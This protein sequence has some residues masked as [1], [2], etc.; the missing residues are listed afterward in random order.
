MSIQAFATTEVIVNPLQVK[1]FQLSNQIQNSPKTSNVSFAEILSSTQKNE[2]SMSVIAGSTSNEQQVSVISGSSSSVEN[3]SE[4]TMTDN[5]GPKSSSD[6]TSTSAMTDNNGSKENKIE[7][8]SSL[9]DK[10]G[11]NNEVSEQKVREN[12]NKNVISKDDSSKKDT[13]KSQKKE[14]DRLSELLQN[15]EK[16]ENIDE[17]SLQVAEMIQNNSELTKKE[18]SKNVREEENS[19]NESNFV[20]NQVQITNQLTE[21]SQAQ[22]ESSQFNFSKNEEDKNQLTLDKEGK[23]TV[24]DLRTEIS[25]EIKIEEKS[26]LKVTE[27]KQTSENSAQITI[28]LAQNV[29][30]DVL[31][32]NSQTASSDGSTF[33]AMLNN[34]IQ[35]NAS[36]FVKAGNIVLKDNNQGTIDLVLHPD[37]LGNVKIH[38]SLDGKTLTGQITVNT[39]EALQVFKDNAE[40]LREAFIKNGFDGASFDV[41]FGNGSN[42]NSDFEF[43]QQNDGTS[44]LAKRI[45]NNSGD[46]AVSSDIEGFLNDDNYSNYSVNIVA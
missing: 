26:D 23:I 29:N 30:S 12:D 19:E 11:Q 38:L 15:Q 33:Q 45:Y 3:S 28:D 14:F 10:N 4:S 8:K 1:D 31:A 7:Q 39:K 42:S 21:N 20:N 27:V 13:K 43:N 2:Q 34:Q 6:S 24:E 35:T 9:K 5:S 22:N 44:L 25:K 16:S 36:E 41:A 46:G 17:K 37:D 40:T 32:L 18:F